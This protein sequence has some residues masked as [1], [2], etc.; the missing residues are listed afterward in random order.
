MS[1]PTHVSCEFYKR[2]SN[3]NVSCIQ[4]DGG[5]LLLSVFYIYTIFW[6][7]THYFVYGHIHVLIMN[8]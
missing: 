3:D 1:S 2:K 8:A 4:D 6:I 7:L 5:M